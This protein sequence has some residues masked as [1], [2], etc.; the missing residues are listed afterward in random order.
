MTVES[1]C[2]GYD[3]SFICVFSRDQQLLGFA[4]LTA[5]FAD[6]YISVQTRNLLVFKCNIV[7]FIIA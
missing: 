1:P 7:I 2:E 3:V 5:V 4:I 6:F